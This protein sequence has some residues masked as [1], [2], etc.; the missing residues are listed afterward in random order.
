VHRLAGALRWLRVPGFAVELLLLVYRFTFVLIDRVESGADALRLRLGWTDRRRRL[1][2][3]GLLAGLVLLRSL[4]QAG[5][6]AEAMRLRGGPGRLPLAP[7]PPLAGRDRLAMGAGVLA[8]AAL[9][10]S[11]GALP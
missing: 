4:D 5:R 10:W 8:V 9:W 6:T 7:L 1:Q 11:A 3:A 2:S